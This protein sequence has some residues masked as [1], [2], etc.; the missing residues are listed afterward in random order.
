MKRPDSSLGDADADSTKPAACL[1]PAHLDRIIIQQSNTV[2]ICR[3]L[4]PRKKTS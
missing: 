1:T 4:P 3:L 2:V